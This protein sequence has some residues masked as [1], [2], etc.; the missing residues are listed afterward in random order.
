MQ[1]TKHQSKEFTIKIEDCDDGNQKSLLN[2]LRVHGSNVV[3]LYL[4]DCCWKLTYFVEILKCLPKLNYLELMRSEVLGSVNVD[5]PEL[6]QLKTLIIVLSLGNRQ[7]RSLVNPN[8]RPKFS[9]ANFYDLFRSQKHLK[10]LSIRSAFRE[11]E[12]NAIFNELDRHMP[13]QLTHLS[14]KFGNVESTNCNNFL[15][16]MET[17]SPTITSLELGGHFSKSLYELVLSNFKILKSLRLGIASLPIDERLYMQLK[18]NYSITTLILVEA[19]KFHD[20]HETL[21]PTCPRWFKEFIRYVPNVTELT[22]HAR[23]CLEATS[24]L[25][26]NLRRLEKLTVQHIVDLN[27]LHLPLHFPKLLSLHIGDFEV[28]TN[29]Q[30]FIRKNVQIKELAVNRIRKYGSVNMIGTIRELIESINPLNLDV[31]RIGTRHSL[32]PIRHSPIKCGTFF[33]HWTDLECWIDGKYFGSLE[34]K[35]VDLNETEHGF[36]RR[37]PMRRFENGKTVIDLEYEL[38][39]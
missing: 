29:W 3:S 25:S 36:H 21:V 39:N 22:L 13:F 30:K 32:I 24:F 8:I 20:S 34:D 17:Q 16:F 19:R 9:P 4:W 7:F 6:K 18:P 35:L 26:Q 12:D 1:I 10:R 23:C 33:S 37:Y 38:S 2:F 5:V 28:D 11:V 15:K 14:L 31:V 27:A